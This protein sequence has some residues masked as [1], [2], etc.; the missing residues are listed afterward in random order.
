VAV[1]DYQNFAEGVVQSRP[2]PGQHR[3]TDFAYSPVKANRTGHLTAFGRVLRSGDTLE[4]DLA[5]QH[6]KLQHFGTGD[7]AGQVTEFSL[8]HTWG[9]GPGGMEQVQPAHFVTG[10]IVKVLDGWKFRC[11]GVDY[12]PV[13]RMA[14]RVRP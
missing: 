5:P 1:W 7:I 12:D 6:E 14:R 8:G 13:G 3:P 10:Q 11:G 9:L 4:V 2:V